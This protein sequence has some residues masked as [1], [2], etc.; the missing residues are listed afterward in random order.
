MSFGGCPTGGVREL[1]KTCADSGTD[2][3]SRE[4]DSH[5]SGLQLNL[6]IEEVSVLGMVGTFPNGDAC[7]CKAPGIQLRTTRRC[8]S[9]MATSA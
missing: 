7:A 5:G 1:T 8:W 2:P 6:G 4:L 9:P 3:L